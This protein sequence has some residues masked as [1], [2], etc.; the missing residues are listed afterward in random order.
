MVCNIPY[1]DVT[2][3]LGPL[4]FDIENYVGGLPLLRSYEYAWTKVDG[5]FMTIVGS[6]FLISNEF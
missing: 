4:E 5:L 1:C 6:S 3:S 2:I